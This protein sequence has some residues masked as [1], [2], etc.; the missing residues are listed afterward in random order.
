MN[1]GKP[2]WFFIPSCGTIGNDR[3]FCGERCMQ[4]IGNDFIVNNLNNKISWITY[5]PI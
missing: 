3:K 1:G 5:D 2:C 4:M